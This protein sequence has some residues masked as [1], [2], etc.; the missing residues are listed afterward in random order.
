MYRL[1][2]VENCDGRIHLV[3]ECIDLTL[4]QYLIDC[5]NK[6]GMPIEEV[7]V[8]IGVVF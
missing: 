1:T 8:K 6:G 2:D 3:F 4:T 5:N 7:K